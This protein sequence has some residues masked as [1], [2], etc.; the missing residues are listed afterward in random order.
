MPHKDQTT[1]RAGFVAIVGRPNVG[2]STLLNRILG[3][4]V[5]IVSPRP[6]TTRSRIL[7]V[8]NLPG[9]QLAFFDTPGLH[10]AKG[11]LNRHMVETA[12]RTLREVEV[13]LLLVEAGTGPGGRVE[14]GEATRWAIQEV[15]R[16]GRPAVLGVNKMDRAP[17][18]TLL[19]VIDAYRGL[20]PWREVVPFSALTGE[21]VDRLLA[22]LS[23]AL[24]EAESPLFPPDVLTDQAERQLAAEYVR[25]QLVLRTRQE[26]P[27]A[28]AVEVEEF[29]ETGRREGGGL[30]RIAASICVERESQKAIVIGRSGSLLKQ[31]G[32]QARQGLERLFGCRVFLAL[33]V[34]VDERWSEREA[35]LRRLGL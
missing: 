27:Y 4:H 14:V 5:A 22:V 7:G 17:R 24:P 33:H 30:L 3:E 23:S 2:K 1:F 29:D 21:N 31:V 18:P 9:A 15:A 11:A 6:Q 25:E 20:H 32:T 8:H 35:S 28:T 12:L 13:V 26:I 16:S 10:R 19:P 34:R